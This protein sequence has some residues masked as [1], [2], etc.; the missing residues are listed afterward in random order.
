MCAAL[1]PNDASLLLE[2]AAEPLLGRRQELCY[3]GGQAELDIAATACTNVAEFAGVTWSML[4]QYVLDMDD[5]DCEV[6]PIAC[7]SLMA[8]VLVNCAATYVTRPGGCVTELH[9]IGQRRL[10][11]A[12]DILQWVAATL[13]FV[14]DLD[15]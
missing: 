7:P 8:R 9:Y 5:C 14:F 12:P 10:S 3:T 11:T 1:V 6:L 4:P 15:E 2:P 13:A